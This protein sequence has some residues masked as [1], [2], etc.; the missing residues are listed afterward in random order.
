MS[1]KTSKGHQE[2]VNLS[3]TLVRLAAA[4]EQIATSL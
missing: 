3:D 1:D 4:Y 2:I